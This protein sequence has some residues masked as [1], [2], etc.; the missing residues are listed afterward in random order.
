MG[1]KEAN[2]VSSIVLG[3]VGVIGLLAGGWGGPFAPKRADG[4]L[5]LSLGHDVPG[6]ARAFTLR[7]ATAGAQLSSLCC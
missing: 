6:G 1:L 2:N 7:W 5:L 4:R 3:A